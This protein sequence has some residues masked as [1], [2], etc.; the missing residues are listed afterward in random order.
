MAKWNLYDPISTTSYDLLVNPDSEV[1]VSAKTLT[2]ETTAAPSGGLLVYEGADQPVTLT[3]SG[4]LLGIDQ[5]HNLMDFYALRHQVQLTDD[6]NRVRWVYFTSFTP[7][8]V[9][10]A[11]F[12]WKFTWSGIFYVLSETLGTNVFNANPSLG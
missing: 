5:Y 6:L 1:T 4:T 12:P 9:R 11:T 8:R 10:S 7:T 2:Y 3:L